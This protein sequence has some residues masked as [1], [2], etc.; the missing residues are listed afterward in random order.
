MDKCQFPSP[1]R[2]LRGAKPCARQ[3]IPAVAPT[4]TSHAK[5]TSLWTTGLLCQQFPQSYAQGLSHGGRSGSAKGLFITGFDPF[6]AH[7]P[8][9]AIGSHCQWLPGL[10]SGP[11]T[12]SRPCGGSGHAVRKEGLFC[13]LQ[14]ARAVAL[15]GARWLGAGWQKPFFD[16]RLVGQRDL[17][18]VLLVIL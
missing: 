6:T 4:G 15:A 1:G 3:G 12:L 17:P 18:G 5:G 2:H 13:G 8:F 10:Q 9:A 14:G 11:L 7:P 16:R